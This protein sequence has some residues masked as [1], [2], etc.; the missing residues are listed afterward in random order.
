MEE[1]NPYLLMEKIRRLEI[2]RDK[3]RKDLWMM[4]RKKLADVSVFLIVIGTMLAIPGTYLKYDTITIAGLGIAFVGLLYMT[5][6]PAKYIRRE[7]VDSMVISPL[8]SVEQFLTSLGIES[9]A[10]YTPTMENRKKHVF[11]PLR[12]DTKIPTNPP[13]N[14]LFHLDKG[15]ET[16]VIH[17]PGGELSKLLEKELRSRTVGEETDTKLST[18]SQLL[19]DGL[20]LAEK[21]ELRR[22]GDKNF[23]LEVKNPEYL[24]LITLMGRETPRVLEQIGCPVSSAIACLLAN[25][26]KKNIIISKMEINKNSREIKTTY[27][28]LP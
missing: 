25:I 21:A 19:V 3:L 1:T 14:R 16:L 11:I 12:S 2:E 17:P 6:S 28:V 23:V 22:D 26:T 13:T 10:I 20:E 9:H 15:E 8:T 18:L 7:I 4:K 27:Q 24:E 5:V